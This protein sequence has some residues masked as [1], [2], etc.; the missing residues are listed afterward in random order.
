MTQSGKLRLYAATHEGLFT[1]DSDGSGVTPAGATFRGAIVDCVKAQRIN[2]ATLF[3]GIAHDGLYRSRDA[4]Q[5]W[6]KRLDGDI[7]AVLI[8]PSDDRVIYV[9]TEPVHL[10]RS[11]DGGER[12]EEI[13]SLQRLPDDTRAK[14][15]LPP[16]PKG[17][18]DLDNPHFRHGRQEWTGPIPPFEGHITEIFVRPDNSD[19]IYLSIEH[20]GIA[21]SFDRGKSWDDA[22]EG[23]DY[24]D[25]HKVVRLKGAAN[26]YLASTSRG[27]YATDDLSKPWIR[28]ESGVARDYFHELLTLPAQ[29]DGAEPLL[30][31]C[32]E[33]SPGNWPATRQKLG[34]W[35]Y[36]VK[37]ARAALYRSDDGARSWH[38]LGAGQGLPEEM[39]PMIWS[40]QRHPSSRDTLFA[41]IGEVGRGFA[42]GTAGT[43]T[44]MVSPD[45]GAS[46]RT[47]ATKL[48]AV[49]QLAVVPA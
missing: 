3:A 28:A 46:W 19:E 20:G 31:C 2:P 25:I 26:R 34:E 21:V 37:G 32:A 41:G 4:G 7:R 36:G 12:F 18:R 1:L 24:L 27:F 5:S 23:I 29:G 39:A 9:G 38:R 40:L 22:S 33:G 13:Q 8:D 30:V 47:L 43:G 45:Q 6:E 15:G 35:T 10:Y 14:L 49:R 11:E 16:E 17:A 48:P 44:I 42:I